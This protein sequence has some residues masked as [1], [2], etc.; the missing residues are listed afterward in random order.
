[1][2]EVVEFSSVKA[3][4]LGTGGPEPKNASMNAALEH[5][6]FSRLPRAE[7]IARTLVQAATEGFGDPLLWETWLKLAERIEP[8]VNDNFT[9]PF[10]STVSGGE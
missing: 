9:R 8:Y 6:S 5:F 4:I 10:Q 2:G 1:M 3:R 7:R